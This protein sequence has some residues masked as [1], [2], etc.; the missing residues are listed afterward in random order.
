MIPNYIT[1]DVKSNAER[2]VFQLIENDPNT[3]DWIVLHSL[4]IPR[5]E[6]LIL[7]EIDFLILAPNLGIFAIEVKGGRISSREGTWYFTNRYNETNSKSRSPFKQA[8]DGMYSVKDYIAKKLSDEYQYFLYGY[9]AIFPDV[10]FDE[11]DI[12]YERWSYCNRNDLES[13][14]YHFIK[15]LSKFSAEKWKDKY[16][17]FDNRKYPTVKQVKAVASLLRKDF[18]KPVLNSYLYN[19]IEKT[20]MSL[21][22]EQFKALDAIADNS[23]I[24]CSGPAGTGKTLLAI[25]ETI[26]SASNGDKVAL[27]C[28]NKHLATYY[29]TFPELVN[30]PNIVFIGTVHSYMRSIIGERSKELDFDNPETYTEEMPIIATDMIEPRYQVDKL[31]LDEGQDVI[32]DNYCMFYD[33]LIRGGFSRGKW[34]IFG[35]FENQRI[36]TPEIID[37]LVDFIADNTSGFV[38]FK[39]KTNCRNTRNIGKGIEI[40]SGVSVEKYLE[41]TEDGPKI[42]YYAGNNELVEKIEDVLDSC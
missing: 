2:R 19:E 37:S 18:D 11:T 39:L 1:E 38:D 12:E 25:K 24:V 8:A 13:G 41:K 7:G 6:K 21:T 32:T 27:L 35:D 42:E 17:F 23:R 3:E 20:I 5:H 22:Q 14:I 4:S 15:K 40:M 28:F 36:Y 9:G 26:R 16:H 10:D 29:Q 34:V 30:N 31:I 33:A